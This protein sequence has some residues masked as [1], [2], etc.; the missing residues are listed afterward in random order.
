MGIPAI[1]A[2]FVTIIEFFGGLLLVVGL[3]VPVVAA[4]VAIQFLGI[5]AMKVWK[6]KAAYISM[7]G[8]KPSYEVDALYL[9]L[10]LVLMVLGAGAVSID[11]VFF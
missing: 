1:T 6:T 11:S 4:F 9:V 8:N 2:I 10:A 7:G 5:I 3:I